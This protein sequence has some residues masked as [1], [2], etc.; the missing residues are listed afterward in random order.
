MTCLSKMQIIYFIIMM[1]TTADISKKPSAHV[2]Q[3]FYLIS[4]KIILIKIKA[5]FFYNHFYLFCL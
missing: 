5:L 2:L 4:E 1:K 3:I